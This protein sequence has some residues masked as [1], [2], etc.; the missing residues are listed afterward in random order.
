MGII[1]SVKV[2]LGLGVSYADVSLLHS[3]HNWSLHWGG[4]VL[5]GRVS[6]G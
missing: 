1:F 2:G 4:V 3:R 6:S 5:L